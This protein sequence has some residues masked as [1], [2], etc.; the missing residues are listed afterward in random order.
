[1]IQQNSRLSV[2]DTCGVVY[3]KCFHVYQKKKSLIGLVG[4]F[5]KVSIRKTH[6]R[7]KQKLRRKKSKAI[8]ITSRQ[9]FSKPDGSVLKFYKNTCVLLKK[10]L[11]PRGKLVKGP[12]VYNFKRK[13]FISS[14]S[15][16]L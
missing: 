12:I 15:R 4:N 9:F 7:L 5:V 16:I 10:R 6:S 2:S 1:M 8:F 14:F 3:V 11:T 13:K